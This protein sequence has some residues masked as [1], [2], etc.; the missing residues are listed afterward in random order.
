[1]SFLSVAR[2]EEKTAS[3]SLLCSD[4]TDRPSSVNPVIISRL[5]C[6]SG[7]SLSRS[8]SPC[9]SI[10]ITAAT[11]ALILILVFVVKTSSRPPV[12]F[13]SVGVDMLLQ[14][15]FRQESGTLAL[16][17]VCTQYRSSGA[18]FEPTA[19]PESSVSWK[20]CKTT[21]RR[22][23]MTTKSHKTT[24]NQPAVSSA[25]LCSGARCLIIRPRA[26][27][28][29]TQ[30]VLKVIYTSRQKMLWKWVFLALTPTE[31]CFFSPSKPSR[32]KTSLVRWHCLL[33]WIH[34]CHSG[35][36][37]TQVEKYSQLHD[38]EDQ[39]LCF[40]FSMLCNPVYVQHFRTCPLR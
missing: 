21:T 12:F 19:A 26:C 17:P 31:S 22:R 30:C 5:C 24:T 2:F 3:V 11:C 28:V 18:L 4:T 34:G 7:T 10:S 1:M 23:T 40:S 13:R 37:G 15:T 32:G 35:C 6:Q 25:C 27:A 14:E 38:P 20:T 36:Y 29:L 8:C 33:L 9:I 16:P 39:S